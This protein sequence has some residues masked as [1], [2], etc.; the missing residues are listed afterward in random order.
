MTVVNYFDDFFSS[1][2]T[3]KMERCK[4][5][6]KHDALINDLWGISLC[7]LEA[8]SERLFML[9]SEHFP[10]V[11]EE[12]NFDYALVTILG[13]VLLR[14]E[15]IIIL[16]KRGYPDGA[17]ALSRALH[18]L[19]VCFIFLIKHRNMNDLI[20]RYFDYIEVEKSKD[21]SALIQT[22]NQLEYEIIQVQDK[23]EQEKRKSDM[24]AKYGN[25]FS[26]DFGWSFC[27]EGINN[28]FDMEKDV[29][30]TVLRNMYR[31][32]CNVIH[33][34]PNSNRYS[35][36]NTDIENN[37]TLSDPSC[38]GLA[39]PAEFALISISALV[40]GI[41][42]YFNDSEF[43]LHLKQFNDIILRITEKIHESNKRVIE[44]LK[45]M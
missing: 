21:M 39:I 40:T 17:M 7:C 24:V 9:F 15:E 23:K 4:N 38:I 43:D 37:N 6:K 42:S 1:I 2:D 31:L 29:G 22:C 20:E 19:T 3:I 45:K 13:K 28:F 26:K 35:L 41:F 32:G 18:E 11:K 16:L 44:L 10:D 5:Y 36:G 25:S 14:F 33:S 27:V 8:L 12:R 34:G 30:A